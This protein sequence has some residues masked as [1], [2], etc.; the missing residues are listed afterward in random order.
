MV[1]ASEQRIK[2]TGRG[3][4]D[5]GSE[6]RA[7]EGE[8]VDHYCVNVGSFHVKCAIRGVASVTDDEAVQGWLLCPDRVLVRSVGVALGRQELQNFVEYFSERGSYLSAA[9]VEWAAAALDRGGYSRGG[10]HE[11]AALALL[12][13][14]EVDSEE[15]DQLEAEVLVR[16]L[17]GLESEHS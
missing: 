13:Q 5:T 10:Q 2:S 11:E 14:D 3:L 1:R 6:A 16:R 4:V 7:W 12:A 17:E 9:F 15:H 8:E